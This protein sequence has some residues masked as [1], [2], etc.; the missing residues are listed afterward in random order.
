MGQ[1]TMLKQSFQHQQVEYLWEK[2]VKTSYMY[3]STTALCEFT[4]K[5]L[6]KNER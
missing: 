3:N 2:G 1:T 5:V 6:M 4:A